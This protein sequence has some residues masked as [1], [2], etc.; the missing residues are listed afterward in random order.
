MRYFQVVINCSER[1]KMGDGVRGRLRV[2]S[3]QSWRAT[4]IGKE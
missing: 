3:G 1:S 4:F 2:G